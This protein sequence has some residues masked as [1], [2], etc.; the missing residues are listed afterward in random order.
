V[1]CSTRRMR[2]VLLLIAL[3]ACL[4]QPCELRQLEDATAGEVRHGVA[5]GEDAD[6][7]ATAGGVACRTCGGIYYLDHELRQRRRVGVALAGDGL[8]AVSGDTTL[9]FDRDFGED[10]DADNDV[11]RPRNFQLFA[12]SATGGELWRVDFGTGEMWHGSLQPLLV[13]GPAS[14][15]IY[16]DFAASVFDP[17]TGAMRQSIPLTQGTQVLP[18]ATGG[19]FI[20]SGA[21]VFNP[22]TASAT[23][24]HLDAGGAELWTTTWST[25]DTRTTDASSIYFEA[26]ARTMDGGLVVAARFTG[27]ALDLGD[28]ILQRPGA[29]GGMVIAVIDGG[30]G[31]RWASLIDTAA[32]LTIAQIVPAGDGVEIG[33]AY[34]GVGGRILPDSE[35]VD[36]YIA[37]VDPAGTVAARAIGGEGFQIVKALAPGGDGSVHV[38]VLNAPEQGRAVMRVDGRSYDDGTRRRWYVLNMLP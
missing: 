29:A 22:G 38:T 10:A 35:D 37:H 4:G 23:L 9:V 36:G 11:G 17:A 1:A 27:P 8:I 26:M 15:V 6:V 12:L 14:A 25:T 21:F 31:V 2:L 33:G 13:A 20:G 16:G 3:S 24:R 5:L 34:S 19:L 7:T 30:G 32:N 28:R 18:D